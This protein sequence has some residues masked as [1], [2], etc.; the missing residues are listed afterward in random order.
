MVIV[1]EVRLSIDRVSWNKDDWTD[2][3]LGDRA[4]SARGSVGIRRS[5]EGRWD[6]LKVLK[7]GV[8]KYKKK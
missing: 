4:T 8:S 2:L 6:R 3:R 1:Q 5:D 7:A